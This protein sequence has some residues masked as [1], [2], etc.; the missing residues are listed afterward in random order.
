MEIYVNGAALDLPPG[1]SIDI[2]ESNPIFN[3]RGTQSIPV[4][5]PP[6]RRNLKILHAPTRI[7]SGSS[8]SDYGTCSIVDG[9]YR[10][11]G[12]INITSTNR[13]EGITFNIGFD[14]S[15]AYSIWKDKKL[16][17]LN[18]GFTHADLNRIFESADPQTDDLAVFPVVLKCDGIE[19][20]E[21]TDSDGNKR[22]KMTYYPETLNMASPTPGKVKRII[23][24]TLTEVTVPAGYGW[25]P[26]LRVWR[27]IEFIFQDI[28]C[29]VTTNPFKD[30]LE[31]A[32]LVVLNNAADSC[33]KSPVSY[34][35]LMPDITVEGFLNSLWVRF[36]LVYNIDYDKR[37]TSLALMRDILDKTAQIALDGN[38]TAFPDITF[39]NPKYIKLSAKTSIDGAE[40]PR[41]RFEDFLKGYALSEILFGKLV[42]PMKYPEITDLYDQFPEDEPEIPDPDWN[43]PDFPDPDYGYDQEDDWDNYYGDDRDYSI[44]HNRRTAIPPTKSA[45][46]ATLTAN[47]QLCYEL[48][49][50]T[51]YKIDKHNYVT[52][53]SG[54]SF[55]NWDPQSKGLDPLDLSSDDECV[56]LSRIGGEGAIM[57]FY[58]V[59]S[60]HYHSYIRGGDG[61]K[62]HQDGE[63]TPLAFMFAFTGLGGN[64]GTVG[65]LSPELDV[66]KPA[67]FP[68]GSTHTISLY[69]QFKNGL[70]SNFWKKYDEILRH[71]NR[72]VE[73]PAR[74]KKSD[75][76]N[77]DTLRPVSIHLVHCL[78]DTLSYSLPARVEAATDIKL[79]TLC[80]Q[81]NYDI[82][83]EQGIPNFDPANYRLEW[84]YS[85]DT[86]IDALNSLESR[87]TAYRKWCDN[88][89]G[90]DPPFGPALAV[91]RV[92]PLTIQPS[93]MTWVTDPKYQSPPKN[94]GVIHNPA[95][96]AVA[97]FRLRA[98]DDWEAAH[99]GID[100]S[101]SVQLDYTA[102]MCA[103]WVQH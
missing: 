86:M 103:K 21:Y 44:S 52:S 37:R 39:E 98:T 88:N 38:V 97:T 93:G 65:R 24:G 58:L 60:R 20:E 102:K 99:P 50:G 70:F 19:G 95:Y 7:D 63:D 75:I 49:T 45:G 83:R 8:P 48:V 61:S 22:K 74:L 91:D 89:P 10:R 1:F 29:P 25:S 42:K 16:S 2:E 17:D 64:P 72:S 87:D 5:V 26:F 32:R 77:L 30:D 90:V 68:D 41:E 84:V 67:T 73:V 85:G 101:V 80:T 55:F 6:T 62:E 79:R 96:K 40:P 35:D 82:A 53:E 47:A 57:P 15:F 13:T 34:S 23:D 46:S 100:L 81:G 43:D 92:D 78:V 76:I 33:C 54:S 51:W 3:D 56:P 28:G 27:V 4:T 71:G 69:F 18:L 66:G 12:K 59:G 94:A 9:L 11:F 36:G 14:N 31:L